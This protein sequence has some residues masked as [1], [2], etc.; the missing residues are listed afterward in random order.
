MSPSSLTI[1]A[2]TTAVAGKESI[3][4]AAQEQ[5][6]ADTVK[7]PGC[8]RYELNQSLD[9]DRAAKEARHLRRAPSSGRRRVQN[10]AGT[11]L[12]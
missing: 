5:L 9:F 8:L 10:A 3:L 12:G 4:R 1:V 7:E 11:S 2:I 6:V